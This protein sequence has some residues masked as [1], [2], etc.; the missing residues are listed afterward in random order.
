MEESLQAAQESDS[1]NGMTIEVCVHSL[2]L[3]IQVKCFIGMCLDFSQCY[4]FGSRLCCVSLLGVWC[5][6]VFVVPAVSGAAGGG[7]GAAETEGGG[8]HHQC[9]KPAPRTTDTVSLLYYP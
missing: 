7:A 6:P 9:Q 2:S 3:K 4:C 5:D 1:S 8:G